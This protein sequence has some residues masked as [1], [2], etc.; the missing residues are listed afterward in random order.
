MYKANEM[1][2]KAF[3]LI[4]TI[5]YISAV[6]SQNCPNHWTNHQSSCYLFMQ[7]VPVDFIEAGSFCQRRASKLVEVETAY[8]NNFL[9]SHI[10]GTRPQEGY[11]IGLSDIVSE[12]EWVWTSTQTKASFVDWTP[13]QPDNSQGHQDCAMFFAPDGFHWNDHFCT[14]K[15]GY[16]CEMD[17]PGSLIG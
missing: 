2:Q 9:R 5:A 6:W 4:L 14:V 15:A 8:E 1:D 12:G 16:I 10:V 11:W 13:N 7:D 3:R 17:L